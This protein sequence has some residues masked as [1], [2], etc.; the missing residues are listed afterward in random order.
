MNICD[1]VSWVFASLY[2]PCTQWV[3][4]SRK[5]TDSVLLGIGSSGCSDLLVKNAPKTI[6]QTVH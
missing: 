3:F 4:D 6:T 5:Q 2:K 1:K